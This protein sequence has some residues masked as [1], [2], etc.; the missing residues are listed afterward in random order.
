[1]APDAFADAPERYRGLIKSLQGDG[2]DDLAVCDILWRQ[3]DSSALKG[4]DGTLRAYAETVRRRIRDE[5]LAAENAALRA[6]VAALQAQVE[7]HRA[8]SARH[9][10]DQATPAPG[11]GPADST[12]G[13]LAAILHY[14]H[15]KGSLPTKPADLKK[16]ALLNGLKYA[17]K[18]SRSRH[19]GTFLNDALEALEKSDRTD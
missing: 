9:G 15:H 17:E 18:L 4:I 6:Q 10:G 1:M 14:Y 3:P 7:N 11:K 13:A 19:L 16:Y 2:L 8:R 12:R 5:G